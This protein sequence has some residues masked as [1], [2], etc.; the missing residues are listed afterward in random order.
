VSGVPAKV[1]GSVDTLVAYRA[2]QTQELPWANLL[3]ARGL[4]GYDPVIEPQLLAMRLAHFFPT[5]DQAEEE[6]AKVEVMVQ[7]AADAV[8][9]AEDAA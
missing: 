7:P 5:E 6:A 3:N 8:Q 4:S 2:Q 1:I 9:L